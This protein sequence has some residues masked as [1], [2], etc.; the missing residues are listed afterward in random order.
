MSLLNDEKINIFEKFSSLTVDIF[1][2][3]QSI[4]NNSKQIIHLNELTSLDLQLFT[5]PIKIG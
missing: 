5:S 3:K 4:F 2:M 1:Q